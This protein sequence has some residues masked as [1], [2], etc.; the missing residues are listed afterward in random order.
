MIVARSRASLWVLQGASPDPGGRPLI[1]STPAPV[2]TSP[3]IRDRSV[4]GDARDALEFVVTG[5]V[6]GS[7]FARRRTARLHRRPVHT[8]R[9]D[10]SIL[11]LR[12]VTTLRRPG[13]R[14]P[15]RRRHH[16]Y[17]RAVHGPSRRRCRGRPRLTAAGVPVHRRA[18]PVR[19]AVAVLVPVAISRSRPNW[20]SWCC[21]RDSSS[22]QRSTR[23]S[24]ACGGPGAASRCWRSR[25]CSSRLPSWPCAPCR[26][27]PGPGT[28]TRGGRDGRGHGPG[29]GHR[30]VQAGRRPAVPVHTRR[31]REPV[32]RRDGHR[33]VRDRPAWRSGAV[34][35]G[36]CR[37]VS[38]VVTLVVSL[39]IGGA[40]RPRRFAVVARVDDHL[41]ETSISLL[42]A[43]GTYLFADASTSRASS[44]PWWRA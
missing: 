7:P 10:A 41:I 29:R 6:T 25:A 44:R 17:C 35:A 16:R 28:R 20:C 42:L 4:T 14:E 33:R 2:P 21:C 43:Y 13:A 18:R 32:Q 31:G 40:R 19:L 27:G 22:R 5:S 34:G 23:T 9:A 8:A 24:I 11:A 38:F 39:A 3:D 1:P 37:V 12:P 26:H 36:R 15:H 30:D